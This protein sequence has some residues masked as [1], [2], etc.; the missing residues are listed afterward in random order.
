MN[1]TR[2]LET[3][4]SILAIP[5][6][7]S[8]LSR[9]FSRSR[10]HKP[11]KANIK[12]WIRIGS[13]LSLSL[14]KHLHTLLLLMLLLQSMPRKRTHQTRLSHSKPEKGSIR[15]Q[16]TCEFLPKKKS[17]FKWSLNLCLLFFLPLRLS[18]SCIPCTG[19]DLPIA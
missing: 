3:S 12:Q 18:F 5:K 17:G 9:R 8:H 10:E 6:Q 7:K 15:K 2:N 1:Y 19:R 14:Y 4:V 11:G 13:I 16:E